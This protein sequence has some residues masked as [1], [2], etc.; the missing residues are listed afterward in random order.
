MTISSSIRKAGPY[1][2]NGITVTFP[3]AFKVFTMAD[4]LVVKAVTA[5]GAETTLTLGSDYTVAL[6][7][8]Q[9]TNP[10]GTVL[11]LVAPALGS[12]VTLASQVANTQGTDLTNLGGFYPKVI[13]DAL[14]RATI[15]IQQLAEKLGRALT[16]GISSGASGNLPNP[17]PLAFLGW[18]S[19]GTALQNFAGAASAAVSTF[20]SNVVAAVDAAAAQT[21][22]GAS[23]VGRA[24][25]G[26]ADAAAARTAIGAQA[27][28]G[29]T[30]ADAATAALDSSV[31]HRSGAETIA[32]VKTFSSAPTWPAG[33]GSISAGTVV[34]LTNQTLVTFTGIPS[35]AK[36]VK[37]VLRGVT[38]A[39][40]AQPQIQ[41]GFGSLQTTGYNCN[42]GAINGGTGQSTLTSGHGLSI[43]AGA[44]VCSGVVE[45]V[46]LGGNTWV[47]SGINSYGNTGAMN[48]ASTDVVLSGPL[49][50]IALG[51]VGDTV[52]FS[53][54]SVNITWE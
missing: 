36:R 42:M 24:V 14:D 16:F 20:M 22:L 51:T 43:A 27:S 50:R 54:G 1:P 12:T 9:N 47:A 15:Q 4:V 34:T 49:D 2:G 45:F 32:G 48:V 18:N 41:I 30:P 39:A 35:C 28:L 52:Q 13:T 6:N 21:A 26:A 7:T 23:A 19:A 46:N 33:S 8:D 25:F 10:G 11:L 31:V 44:F 3:F 17:T 37:M 5:T 53:N 29:Y 38:T 40:S